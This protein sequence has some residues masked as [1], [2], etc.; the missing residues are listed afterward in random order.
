M[1][2]AMTSD[3]EFTANLR[4]I[5]NGAFDLLAFTVIISSGNTRT[6][7][8]SLATPAPRFAAA[9]ARRTFH[10][11]GVRCTTDGYGSN[12]PIKT[13]SPQPD[14]ASTQKASK[15]QGTSILSHMRLVKDS[16]DHPRQCTFTTL[17]RANK[18]DPAEQTGGGQERQRRRLIIAR[19]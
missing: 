4:D 12:Q 17:W 15:S 6:M 7:F 19:S 1:C 16:H 8:R 18:D 13:P 2:F 3:T 5:N 14:A 10:A 11:S 9:A